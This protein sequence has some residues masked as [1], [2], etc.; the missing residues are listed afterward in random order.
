MPVARQLYY[1]KA[2]YFEDHFP[3]DV[4]VWNLRSLRHEVR[5][6]LRLYLTMAG[7]KEKL[8]I[9]WSISI[10]FELGE[11]HVHPRSFIA[12]VQ[13]AIDTFDTFLHE[14]GD[15]LHT[16]SPSKMIRSLFFPLRL[17]YKTDGTWAITRT[18]YIVHISK[19]RHTISLAVISLCISCSVPNAFFAP[20]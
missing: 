6:N 2:L 14:I 7:G 12:T 19:N 8:T 10:D 9:Q 18:G 15:T 16:Y 20:R 17:K 5:G 3:R 1:W 4:C 11:V 13:M